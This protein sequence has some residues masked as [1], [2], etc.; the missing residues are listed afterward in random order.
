[1]TV[2]NSP[3]PGSNPSNRSP[4]KV[5]PPAT[6]NDE[7]TTLNEP[8]TVSSP[9]S[10]PEKQ[11]F[12]RIS[13]QGLAV[14]VVA[15]GLGGISLIPLPHYVTGSAEVISTQKARQ[16]VTMPVEGI[17]R[18][19]VEPNQ[20]VK[21]GQLIAEVNS[22]ELEDKIAAATL[23]LEQ[24]HQAVLS[25]YQK[26]SM[27]QS[28]LQVA[29]TEEQNAQ[30]QVDKHRA[31]LKSIAQ[32]HPLPQIRQL[33]SEIGGLNSE[34]AGYRQKLV[35]VEAEIQDYAPLAQEGALPRS[36]LRA[37]MKEQ[38]TLMALTKETQST[39]SGKSHAIAAVTKQLLDQL[40]AVDRQL[41]QT[42]AAR[43]SAQTVV[44]AQKS[45]V[46]SAEEMVVKLTEQLQ[47]LEL[48]KQQLQLR[49]WAEGTV[50]K[51]DL[52]LLHN[53]HL[54]AGEEILS[55]VDLTHLSAAVQVRQEDAALVSAGLSVTFH[56]RDTERK[57]YAA[58]VQERDIAPVVRVDETQQQRAIGVRISI[59]NDDAQLRPG[60]K[61]TAHIAVGKMPIYQK[62]Q[63]EFLRLV[64]V[65]RWKFF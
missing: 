19:S 63:R 49:A 13:P 27:A 29:L 52:D 54:Q 51:L 30:K 47:R 65:E 55:I 21:P 38:V 57:F 12:P 61:G 23:E 35:L 28:Q 25:G 37:L 53:R 58:Q 6:Q 11:S 3:Y 5:I 40:E 14:A 62:V 56:P 10:T 34:M 1:M 20:K 9:T 16:T 18:L 22:D 7:V 59:D 15:M 46:A 24:A 33:E 2:T 60:E 45:A 48:S 26:L 31:E 4:L 17:V 42:Q 8:S 64:P 41:A 36:T 50:V 39:I 44:L 43:V 32:G